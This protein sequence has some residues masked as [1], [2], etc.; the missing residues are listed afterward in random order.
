MRGSTRR[1]G[2][3]PPEPDAE[4]APAAEEPAGSGNGVPAQ[5]PADLPETTIPRATPRP[6]PK[7]QPEELFPDA[8][9]LGVND[10]GSRWSIPISAFLT[11]RF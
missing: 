4:A 5:P 8:N 10:T 11:V 3:T 6:Q 2:R 7:P 1:A 9:L